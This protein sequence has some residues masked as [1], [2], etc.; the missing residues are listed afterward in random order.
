MV[1]VGSQIVFKELEGR[2]VYVL[3]SKPVKRYEF[4]LGKFAGFASVLK[5]L[6]GVQF[7]LLL[8]VLF[9]TK[10][11]LSWLLVGAIIGEYLSL[12]I[13]FALSLFFSTFVSP[14]LAILVTLAIYISA[15]GVSTVVDVA[16]QKHE[17]AL[18]YIASV[19][20]AILPPLEGLNLKTVLATQIDI[21]FLQI[22]ISYGIGLLYLA[23]ILWATILLF[24][25][26]TFER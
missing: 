20:A 2:T 25:K 15:H 22:L 17:I 6:L 19:F 23:V 26:K 12:L 11:E 3:L 7:L 5:I 1:F 9:F 16:L 21:P 24:N 10:S 18:V 4:I 13:V 8:A 14:L